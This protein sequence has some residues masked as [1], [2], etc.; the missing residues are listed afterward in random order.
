M[1]GVAKVVVIGLDGLEP[2]IVE[3]M[4]ASGELP[5]LARLR[6]AGGYAR[7][8]TTFPAQTPVAW[9][10]F[11]TGVN[12]GG[13]GIFDFI[14]RDPGTYRPDLALNRYERRSAFLPPKAVNLRR[15][16]PLWD[17]LSRAGIPS[18]VIRCPC[19]YPPDKIEGRLLSGMGVPDLRGGLG[20]GTF[21]STRE[22]VTPGEGERVVRIWP[23]ARGVARSHL[24]G[25]RRPR[26][27]D[28]VLRD[29][30]IE[31]D[32]TGRKV[33]IRADAR[34]K[35]L[36]VREGEWSDWLRV[37][38][39]AGALQ[40]VRGMVRFLL[41]RTEP[42]VELYAS[43]VNFDPAAPM[44]PISHPW[45]YAAELQRE[46]DTFHTTGMAEDHP[47]LANQRFDEQ[48]FLDQC[49]QVLRERERM[50]LFELERMREGFLFCLFDTPDRVQHMFWRFGEPGHPANDGEERA[51]W[52][53]VIEAHYRECDAIVGRAMERA[54]DRTLFI[55]LSDHGFASFQR[56]VHLNGW[57]HDHGFLALQPG[58][59]PGDEGGDFLHH[60]D[61]GRTKAYAL[62]LGAVYLNLE[63]REGEGIVREEDASSVTRDIVAGLTGLRDDARGTVAVRRVVTR[64]EIYSGD[65]AAESPDMVACFA[66]GYRASWA[67]ALGGVRAGLVEDNTRRWGG[68]HVIDP[69]LVPGVLF[70]SRPFDGARASLLDLAPTILSALGVPKGEAMEGCSLL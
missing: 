69:A 63:G 60:V 65:C 34:P 10:T 7:C 58:H 44:F 22:R 20:T 12:P 38:F 49:A 1:E 33:T 25:P 15:G 41:V 39:D 30:T 40:R 5:N 16:T 28:D 32:R 47:G 27:G 68:D 51:E 31:M 52:R 17:L 11:A 59:A 24:I 3:R 50:L 42:E 61:W 43:P 64:E 66:P 35:A 9:S 55:A 29:M 2:T 23:D 37:A 57:L 21:Y 54:D 18:T 48:A 46:V 62:G 6:A 45:E 8:R 53:Q 14:R 70:M 26:T 13:H 56:G 36:E 19:T 4:L 67:T